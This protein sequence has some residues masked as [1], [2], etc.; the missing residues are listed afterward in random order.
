MGNRVKSRAQRSK[1]DDPGRFVSLPHTV[2]TSRA[3]IELPAAAKALLLDMLTQYNGRNNGDICAA[4]KVMKQRGWRSE[5][6]LFRARKALEES[7]LISVTRAGGRPNRATLYGF[8]FYA[9]D[10]NPKLEVTSRTFPRSSWKNKERTPPNILVVDKA[11]T[12]IIDEQAREQ[13]RKS[14]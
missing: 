14:K 2:L 9:L 12:P 11:A 10:D 3:L 6:T 4:F 13:H 5:E 7:E 8:T 1:R